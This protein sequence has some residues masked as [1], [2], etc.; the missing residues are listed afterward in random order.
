MT[1]DPERPSLEDLDARLRA[2]RER[3]EAKEGSGKS[4]QAE[5][6]GGLGFALR[7]GTDLVAALIV[8]VG[9]GVLLDYWLG[10]KPWMLVLFFLLGAAAGFLNIFRR[11]SGY[12]LAA[13]YKKPETGSRD[14]T[15][16]DKK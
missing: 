7:I 4:K 12:G 16:K 13:G 9:I 14:E 2:A 3:Q 8:G 1:E 10:T 6:Q 5:A 11:V 15:V